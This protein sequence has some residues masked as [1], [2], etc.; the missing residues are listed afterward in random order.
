MADQLSG[1]LFKIEIAGIQ[2]AQ[3]TECSGFETK[4][5]VEEYKE[6]GVNDFVHKL[7]GRQ[8]FTNVTFK[9]GMLNSIELW[10][11]LR[12][13][14]AATAKKDEKKNISVVLYNGAGKEQL[15]WDLL[16]AF[17]V[18]WSSPALQSEQSTI[19]VESLEIAYREFSLKKGEASPAGGASA[20]A[21]A[22]ASVRFGA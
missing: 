4:L 1:F 5:D 20:E 9:R 7:P 3:F 17:P 11:W 16:D 15:R 18:K 19:L 13:I 10:D 14:S 22:S 2:E 6:G 12:R 21:S 8:S